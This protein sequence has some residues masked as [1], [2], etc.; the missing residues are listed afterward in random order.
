V[1]VAHA[2]TGLPVV[3]EAFRTGRWSYSKVRA[4]TRIATA[5]DETELV[6]FAATTTAA[7]VEQH[8]PARQ[9]DAPRMEDG[10]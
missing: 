1:R 5:A 9:A 6:E 4:V 10:R 3:D 7:H 2:P 8:V